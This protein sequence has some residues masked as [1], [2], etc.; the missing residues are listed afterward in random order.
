M[1]YNNDIS[2]KLDV[3]IFTTI[4]GRVL[5]GELIN[6]SDIGVELENVF[7]ID[8]SNP[9]GMVPI[10]QDSIM[11]TSIITLYDKIIETETSVNSESTLSNYIQHCL[12]NTLMDIESNFPKKINKKNKDTNDDTLFNWRNRFN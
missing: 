1:K 9:E 2:N 5:I 8:P 12:G 3:R 7:L 10:H 6:V 4:S 11:N